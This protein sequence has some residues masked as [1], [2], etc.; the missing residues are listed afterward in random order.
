MKIKYHVIHVD[1]I[2][3]RSDNVNKI[4][5]AMQK[6]GVEKLNAKVANLSNFFLVDQFLEENPSF[7]FNYHNEF[8][9]PF[10]HVSGVVGCWASHWLAWGEMLK[11]NLDIA[12]VLEDDVY[13]DENIMS[14]LSVMIENLPEGWDFFSISIPPG[15]ENRY[16]LNNYIDNE[17]VCSLYQAWNTGGYLISRSGALK[18]MKDIN[19]NGISV[20]VD[21]YIFDSGRG[22]I[23][24]YNPMPTVKKFV[25]FDEDFNNS[26]IGKTEGR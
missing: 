3:Q 13:I 7:V 16:S 19:K 15:E 17:Y 22:K 21:W 2:S 24:T 1:E 6:N 20:P 14:V 5:L 10:P 11:Q 18:V 26:Y 23:N 4:H 9:N 25:Y 8:E 12:I